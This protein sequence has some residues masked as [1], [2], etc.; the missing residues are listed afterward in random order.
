MKG[1]DEIDTALNKSQTDAKI[2]PDIDEWSGKESA[3]EITEDAFITE[4][5]IL[6]ES[7]Y[8][9]DDIFYPR[10]YANQLGYTIY[11][12]ANAEEHFS[13]RHDE[14]DYFIIVSWDF[15]GL[16][17]EKNGKCYSICIYDR[18]APKPEPDRKIATGSCIEG[19]TDKFLQN[20]LEFL[21]IVAS[22]RDYIPTSEDMRNTTY[23]T[24]IYSC[25]AE[26]YDDG[27]INPWKFYNEEE[28]LRFT[29]KCNLDQ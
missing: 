3:A 6:D 22:N 9:I 7:K 24:K 28:K 5:P 26:Y 18:I 19:N 14:T 15:C 13:I 1:Q 17:Y 2:A 8:F 27:F 16:F 20:E 10:E 21:K 23:E 11:E 12:S 25:T 29:R 4:E